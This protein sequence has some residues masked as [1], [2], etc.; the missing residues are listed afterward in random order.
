[1]Y[2][3]DL[4][5]PAPYYFISPMYDKIVYHIAITL[6]NWKTVCMVASYNHVFPHFHGK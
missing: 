4:M 2:H 6:N 3:P 1:M 5:A